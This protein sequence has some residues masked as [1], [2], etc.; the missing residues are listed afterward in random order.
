MYLGKLTSFSA[1]VI[2]YSVESG[3]GNVCSNFR[4]RHRIWFPEQLIL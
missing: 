1:E 3:I 2:M 4:V